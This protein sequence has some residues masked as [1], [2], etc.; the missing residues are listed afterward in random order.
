MTDAPP[1]LL[2]ER[3]RASTQLIIARTAARLFASGGVADTTAEQIAAES[4]VSLRTFYRHF[5]T[6]QDAVAPLLTVGAEHWRTLLS[7]PRPGLSPRAVVEATIRETLRPL[8]LP[9]SDPAAAENALLTRSLLLGAATD[10]ALQRIWFRVNGDSEAGLFS[11]M[12]ELL[13]P[14]AEPHAPRLLAAA[15]TAAIRAAL[16]AWAVTELPPS[17]PESAPELAARFFRA[18][19]AGIVLPGDPPE[20]AADARGR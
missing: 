6:K 7:V 8:T 18:L 12:T 11:V 20:G 19:S 15:G 16:E 3:R 9:L 1:P 5:P 14:T 4:G 10:E 13:G 2:S 17:G